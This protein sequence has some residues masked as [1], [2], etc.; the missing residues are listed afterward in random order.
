MK[1]CKGIVAY[2]DRIVCN[3]CRRVMK[4]GEYLYTD[5]TQK[6]NHLCEDCYNGNT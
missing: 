5:G 3:K 2:S 1:W 6:H 4:A